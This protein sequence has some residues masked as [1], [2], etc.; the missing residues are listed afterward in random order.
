MA[1]FSEPAKSIRFNLPMRM[2]SPPSPVASFECTVMVK[3]QCERD[4]DALRRVAASWRLMLLLRRIL[5]M[6][7]ALVT[8]I[9]SRLCTV[10][11]SLGCSNR[12]SGLSS[13]Q[14]SR[15]ISSSLNSSMCDTRTLFSASMLP[16]RCE[17]TSRTARGIMPDSGWSADHAAPPSRPPSMVK[18]LPVP[19]WPYANTVQL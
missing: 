19:V 4:D 18:V 13:L 2:S 1:T 12:R 5:K 17:K 14:P 10:T 15:S 9:C 6:A 3:M 7:S 8:G 11:P 16:S